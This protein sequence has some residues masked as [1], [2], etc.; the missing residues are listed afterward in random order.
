MLSQLA[1]CTSGEWVEGGRGGNGG[2]GGKAGLISGDGGVGGAGGR[3]D[4][5]RLRPWVPLSCETPGMSSMDMWTTSGYWDVEWVGPT[6][7][8]YSCDDEELRPC[9]EFDVKITNA[10]VLML[11]NKKRPDDV[12]IFAPHTWHSVYH[13]ALPPRPF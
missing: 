2:A 7:M 13:A 6:P 8:A 10:G 12:H 1:V 11:R 9:Q 5:Q 4:L 3:V